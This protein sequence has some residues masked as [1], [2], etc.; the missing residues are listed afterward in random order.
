MTAFT[1]KNTLRIP[2]VVIILVLILNGSFVLPPA[3]AD[4]I[5]L[6]NGKT[7][8]GIIGAQN[9]E[10]L[11][12]SVPGQMPL[13]IYRSSIK[14]IEKGTDKIGI[15]GNRSNEVDDLKFLSRGAYYKELQEVLKN[16][17]KS[18]SVMMYLITYK[19]QPRQP[20]DKLVNLLVDAHERGVEVKVLL[21]SST[22]EFVT[23]ANRRAAAYLKKKGVD[24]RIYPVFPI[25]HVKLVIIDRY[26]SIVG[27]H[28]WTLASTRSNVESSVLIK[29]ERI[30]HQYEKYFKNNF[31]RGSPYQDDDKTV[32]NMNWSPDNSGW[33]SNQRS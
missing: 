23:Q 32:R 5:T 9:N 19:G 12:L 27:S 15:A 2:L 29:S 31:N 26:I 6:K 11:L 7:Y 8:E 16:A 24:V 22:E 33:N 14:S 28:N 30:A 4:I 20:A 10:T 17:K 13:K 3:Q 1:D 21:E 18:I 25:M